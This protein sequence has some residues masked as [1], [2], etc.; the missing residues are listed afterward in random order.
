[1]PPPPQMSLK[2]LTTPTFYG[3]KIFSE[4]WSLPLMFANASQLAMTKNSTRVT[5]SN[6]TQQG[7]TMLSKNKE[8]Q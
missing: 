1:M 2:I 3:L 7:V 4:I 8:R 5:V 6:K